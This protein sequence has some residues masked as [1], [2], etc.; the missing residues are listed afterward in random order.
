MERIYALCR[1]CGNI[2]Y[3]TAENSDND[4]T[5]SKAPPTWTTAGEDDIRIDLADAE[6]LT[7]IACGCEKQ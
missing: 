7:L 6:T 1:H 3:R 2:V 4:R 5:A